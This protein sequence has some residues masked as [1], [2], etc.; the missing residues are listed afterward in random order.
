MHSTERY[1]GLDFVRAIAMMLGVVLHT[2]MLFRDDFHWP[3]IAGEYRGDAINTFAVKFIH[4]FRMQLFIILAG[5]FAE[6]VFQRKGM[7]H[8]AQDRIKR[9]FV[10]FLVGIFIFVPIIGI[11]TNFNPSGA[12]INLFDQMSGYE[13]FKSFRPI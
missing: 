2:S 9:I 11:L 13:K 4:F 3:M 6:L 1:H 8:L 10:P 12:F 7:D 5:F